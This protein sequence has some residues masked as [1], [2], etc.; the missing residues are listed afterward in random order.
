MGVFF[1]SPYEQS[2]TFEVSE[3]TL[4]K[5]QHV[6]LEH[7]MDVLLDWGQ[8]SMLATPYAQFPARKTLIH[9]MI[10]VTLNVRSP[11]KRMYR[12]VQLY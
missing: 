5:Q 10:S 8:L 11:M 12:N 4:A 3:K 9:K 7:L 6:S 1:I 2:L